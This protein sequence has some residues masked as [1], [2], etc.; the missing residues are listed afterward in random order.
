M[1]KCSYDS[2]LF[3]VLLL[4]TISMNGFSKIPFIPFLIFSFNHKGHCKY[5]LKSTMRS[6]AKVSVQTTAIPTQGD[7]LSW[8]S[9]NLLPTTVCGVYKNLRDNLKATLDSIPDTL[10][11]TDKATY[12]N[13]IMAKIAA[14][15]Q[16]AI[17]PTVC[18]SD[19][20][21]FCSILLGT[22][23][24]YPI[25][26]ELDIISSSVNY[27]I[28]VNPTTYQPSPNPTNSTTL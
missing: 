10:S 17:Y 5:S 8:T 21:K 9:Y 2:S 26:F 1:K 25:T 28:Y 12:T 3:L 7:Y 23:Q 4:C 6:L 11:S 27:N 18:K 14:L 19:S 13:N 16:L 22:C 15:E 24:T 20:N